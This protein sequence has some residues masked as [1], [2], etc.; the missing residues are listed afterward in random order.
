MQKVKG[1]IDSGT[2]MIE[3]E[4]A[5]EDFQLQRTLFEQCWLLSQALCLQL[6][7]V[8]YA[9]L[10]TGNRGSPVMWALGVIAH[11]GFIWDQ[12]SLIGQCWSAFLIAKSH[13]LHKVCSITELVPGFALPALGNHKTP[14]PGN[15]IRF[16]RCPSTCACAAG[17]VSPS[18][19]EMHGTNMHLVWSAISPWVA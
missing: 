3:I 4:M 12:L 2:H 10:V 13:F 1:K 14:F 18:K 16:A 6:H 7:C 5:A 9:K 15:R 11:R 19:L 8:N 17:D